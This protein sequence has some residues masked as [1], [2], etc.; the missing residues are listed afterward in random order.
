MNIVINLTSISNFLHLPIDIMLWRLFVLVGWIPIAIAFLWGA[1]ELWLKYIRGKWKEKNGK[2]I[3]LAIDIPRGNEK[4][5][6]GVENL[7]RK[8]TR[9]NSSHTDISRMPSSA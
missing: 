7:D 2:Y 1:K 8:S 4:S 5:P 9:L 6:K 3:I